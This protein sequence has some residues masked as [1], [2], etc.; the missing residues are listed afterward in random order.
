MGNCKIAFVGDIMCGDSFYA[1]G[2]GVASGMLKYGLDFLPGEIVDCFCEHDLV[3]GNIESPISEVGRRDY[4]LRTIHMRGRSESAKFL[5]EWGISIGNVANN[6]ILEHGISAACDTVE[7]L[8]KV[9]IVAIGAGRNKELGNGVQVEK[10]TC[11]DLNLAFI[12]VCLREEKYAFCGGAEIDEVISEIKELAS[13]N[14]AVVVSIHWG[15]EFMNRPALWQK[16]LAMSMIDSGATIISGHHPHVVQGIEQ[17]NGRLIAYSLGNF[18]F[19]HYLD[20]T[21]WSVILSVTLEDNKVVKW[22]CIPVEED[23]EH[24][25][26]LA[27]GLSRTRADDEIKHRCDL[28]QTSVSNKQYQERYQLEVVSMD[29]IAR[30]RLYLE[31]LKRFLQFCPVYWPQL[32]FRPIQ[33]RLNLW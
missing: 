29:T 2:H 30:H 7:Q 26:W 22:E 10:M 12:G 8:R 4:L 25:P 15:D 9:G 5:A 18:L 21:R 14:M 31:L 28:L 3:M 20:D 32:L 1:I 27:K 11:G 24:R 19:D 16:E 13:D 33:R 17:V 6:H 23:N